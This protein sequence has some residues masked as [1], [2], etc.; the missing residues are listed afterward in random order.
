MPSLVLVQAR[1]PPLAMAFLSPPVPCVVPLNKRGSDCQV[2][3]RM[4][5]LMASMNRDPIYLGSSPSER[6]RLAVPK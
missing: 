4:P 5:C 3:L 6:D 1:Y 2:H